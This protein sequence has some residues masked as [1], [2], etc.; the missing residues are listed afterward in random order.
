MTGIITKWPFVR[1]SQVREE[2]ALFSAIYVKSVGTNNRGLNKIIRCSVFITFV[3]LV[4]ANENEAS[5][6]FE[7]LS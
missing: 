6:A 2:V 3:N 5:F 1:D 7:N 4:K